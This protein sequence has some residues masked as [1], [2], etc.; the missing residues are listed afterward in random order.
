MKYTCPVCG[1]LTL[2]EPPGSYET[3]VVCGWEDDVSQLLFPSSLGANRVSL[4]Q[5]QNNFVKIGFSNKN[6]LLRLLKKNQNNYEKDP[7]WRLLRAADIK[8]RPADVD[9]SKVYPED[10][11]E[12]YYWRNQGQ[13]HSTELSS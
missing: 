10:I 6:I 8:D 9:P 12:L 2:K 13:D 3:C 5:A 7:Q 1:F 11:T 4:Q